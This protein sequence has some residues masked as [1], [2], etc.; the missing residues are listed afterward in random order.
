MSGVAGA[1]RI[2]S[3]S[4]FKQFVSSYHQ[5]MTQFPGYVSMTPSGSYNSNPNKQDFGDIDLVVYIQSDK[6]KAAVKKELQAFFMKQPDTVIAPFTSVKHS[7]K[8]TYNA[9]ELVSVRYNDDTVGYSVQIDNI[10][11]LDPLEA[12]F[13]KAFL[14]MP[15]EEQGLALGLVKIATIETEPALLFDKLGI[16]APAQLDTDQEYEFNLSG[17]ELQLRK[18]TYESGTFKQISRDVIWSSKNFDHL[19]TLLYQYDLNA[20]FD[21][22]LEQ[23]KQNIR[24]PRSNARMQGVFSSMISVKSGEVGTAK[25]AGKEAALAKVQQAF[26]PSDNKGIVFAFGRFQPPTVGHELLVNTVKQIADEVG[27]KHAIYVSKTYDHKANPL[28]V[29]QKITYLRKMFPDV[30]FVATDNVVRTPIEAAKHLNQTYDEL[31]MVAGSDRVDSFENLLNTYNGKEY[32]YQS[33]NV[34]S[35][36]DR[37]PDSDDATGMSGTKMREAAMADNFQ[38]FCQGLPITLSDSDA[39]ALMNQVRT[40]LAKPQKIKEKRPSNVRKIPH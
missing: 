37:D 17:V 23:V 25:G 16:I 9:G 33:I 1:D 21:S 5:L 34:V 32:Q 36:G 18:V 30:N 26:D 7:G 27:A 35:A 19:A 12:T 2:K 14:D 24:N 20:G 3:R 31:I 15:A 22:L 28:T 29:E 8:R 10:V 4:D 11:A 39:M 38:V 6:D 13:K 40:G